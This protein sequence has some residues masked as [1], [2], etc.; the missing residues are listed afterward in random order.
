MRAYGRVFTIPAEYAGFGDYFLR[1]QQTRTNMRRVA[2]LM[3]D[4]RD[5]LAP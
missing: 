4:G 5:L 2:S 1:I 3:L